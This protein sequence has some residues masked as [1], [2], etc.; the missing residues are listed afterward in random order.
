[1]RSTRFIAITAI[2]T[3]ATAHAAS[4]GATPRIDAWLAGMFGT[5]GGSHLHIKGANLATPGAPTIVTIGPYLAPVQSATNTA[6]QAVIPPGQGENLPITIVTGEGQTTFS[7]PGF[8]YAAPVV[9]GLSLNNGPAVADQ[10]ITIYGS[11]FGLRPRVLLDGLEQ[12]VISRS[13]THITFLRTRE[14]PVD[15]LTLEVLVDNQASAPLTFTANDI[16]ELSVASV[17]PPTIP[18]AGGVEVVISGAGFFGDPNVRI[19]GAPVSAAVVDAETILATAPAGAGTDID[20]T[21]E[22]LGQTET[23]ENALA[24]AP[25]QINNVESPAPGQLLLTGSNFGPD[26]AIT[27]NGDPTLLLENTHTSA[28]VATTAA[29]GLVTITLTAANQTTAPI[30]FEIPVTCSAADLNADGAVNSA[31]LGRLLGNWGPCP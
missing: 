4:A 18:T 5:S 31:D 8:S 22:T 24:Y 15:V 17:T 6:I 9:D 28:R 3:L 14:L 2:A 25:P 16:D 20:I 30:Q 29:P 23:V 11:S 21:V 1:M 27:V 12:T 26:P 7:Q 10:Q 19:N 13:H